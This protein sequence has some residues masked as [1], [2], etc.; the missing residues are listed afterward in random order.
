[1][2]PTTTY[3]DSTDTEFIMQF[4]VLDGGGRVT[5]TAGTKQHCAM[6]VAYFLIVCHQPYNKK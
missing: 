3:T 1:V 4:T 5:V 2:T 6:R